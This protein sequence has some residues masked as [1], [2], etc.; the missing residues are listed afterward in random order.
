MLQRV[1]GVTSG[2]KGS[3]EGLFLIRRSKDYFSLS[4]L[5]KLTR[6]EKFLFCGFHKKMFFKSLN[7]SYLSR[8]S[9]NTFSRSIFDKQNT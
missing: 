6:L 8:T 4:I 7:A 9:T 1:I 5:H 2:C 3:Y